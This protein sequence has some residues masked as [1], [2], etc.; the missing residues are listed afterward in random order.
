MDAPS[1]VTPLV[2]HGRRIGERPQGI[3]R[4]LSRATMASMV[5]AFALSFVVTAFVSSVIPWVET[6]LGAMYLA[7]MGVAALAAVAQLWCWITP[8]SQGSLAVDAQGLHVARALAFSRRDIARDRVEA[9][10]LVHDAEGAEVEFR[11]HNGDELSVSVASPE[12][13][14]AVLD[15]AGVDPSKR[16]LSMQMGGPELNVALAMGSLIPGSCVA[17]IIALTL[18]SVV[19]LPSVAMGFLLFTL[20][21]LSIPLSL[22]AFGPPRVQVGRDGVSVRRGARAWFASFEEISH[23]SMRGYSLVLHLR[24][25][26]ERVI[27]G[28][29]TRASRRQALG[30]RIAAG[31]LEAHAP[32]D[33]SARLTAL[34]RNGRTIEEWSA[35]LRDVLTEREAY[36]STGLTRDEVVAALEDPHA[37]PDRRIGAAYALSFADKEQTSQRVRV[38]VETIAHEPVRVALS[39]AADGALD[40]ESVTAATETLVRVV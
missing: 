21:A 37:T 20:A 2:L 18:N 17:S 14:E 30:D 11:L 35:A 40:E 6:L 13:A 9:G 28:L 38:A 31:V 1:D 32:R 29:G 5:G 4:A 16:A 23:V 15:A 19:A 26:S 7:T 22:R 3:A 10:W 8:K 12:E 25:G 24:D 34:D 39:R 33:L 27:S 36:R